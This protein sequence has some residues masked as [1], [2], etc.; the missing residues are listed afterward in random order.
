MVVF[1]DLQLLVPH[2][3]SPRKPKTKP[4]YEVVN[5]REE[6]DDELCNGVHL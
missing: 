4:F 2:V 5:D 6:G 1:D 3:H